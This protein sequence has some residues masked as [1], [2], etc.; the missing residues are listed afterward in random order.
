[1]CILPAPTT[2]GATPAGAAP[3]VGMAAVPAGGGYW[4]VADNG[5]VF[6][7][8][9]AQYYGSMAGRPLTA[10]IVGMA[11]TPDGRGYWLVASDGGI[12]SFGDAAFFGSTGSLRLNQPI[13]GLAPT[14]DGHGYW[15][16]ASD[17]GIFSFGD[18]AFHGSTGAMR[19][20]RP[21]VGMAA[22]PD[23][24]GYWLVASDGGI[25]SFGDAAF[26]GSTGH[27]AL[28]SPIVGMAATPDGGGYRM[29]AG[30]GGIFSFGDATFL[31]STG[32]MHLAQPVVGMAPSPGG[33]W[34][35]QAD[36]DTFAFGSARGGGP[37]DGASSI[38]SDNDCQPATAPQ[39]SADTWLTDEFTSQAGPGWLGGDATYSTQLPNGEEDF[40][41]SDTL[42]GTAQPDGQASLTGLVHNSELVGAVNGLQSV[43]GGT[44]S[45]PQTFIPDTLDDGGQWQVGATEVENGQQLIFV[46]EFTPVPGSEFDHYN[47]RSAVAVLSIPAQGAPTLSAMVSVPTDAD[48]QW[49]EAVTQDGTYSYVFG[50]G[51]A[52]ANG[53]Y[54]GMKVARV[55]LGQTL[56][57]AAWQYWN[58]SDW[59]PGESNAALVATGNELTGVVPQSAGGYVAVSIP[60]GVYT[61]KTLDVSYACT[62]VGPWTTPQPV[63]T[64]PQLSQYPNEI[65]YIPTA[66]PELSGNGTLVVSYDID[67]LSGLSSVEADVHQYQPQFVDLTFG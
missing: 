48:T 34:L 1:L 30:D 12:F 19:L 10:P 49:G 36:G 3:V 13:V 67:S 46:N 33:Y 15:L 22:T 23:G 41:F 39:A 28:V 57:T 54:A 56:D 40:V 26:H 27:L 62:P 42:I 25:F 9:N 51:S 43:Y 2:G 21:V 63:Y 24:H 38:E 66:H 37:V 52:A 59:G 65:A 55:P 64:I 60:G 14:P 29:V 5:A 7:Y 45:A 6:A 44:G 8:G 20:N 50:Q 4:D 18:A 11:A 32:G 16:V 61:D 35:V 58:G 31:G 53:S 47:G 17:G